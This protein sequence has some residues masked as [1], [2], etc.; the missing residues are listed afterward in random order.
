MTHDF[1]VKNLLIET[2]QKSGELLILSGLEI[3]FKFPFEMPVLIFICN[4]LIKMI[5][6]SLILI[7]LFTSLET[8][9]EILS[10]LT[11]ECAQ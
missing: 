1:I 6:P 2:E 4:P 8:I 5:L 9:L 7:V 10:S 11:S 3:G